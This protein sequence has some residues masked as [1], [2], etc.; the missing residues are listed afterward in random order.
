MEKKKQEM[1][2]D[3]ADGEETL[4]KLE[5]QRSEF[6]W[7]MREQEAKLEE[8]K[9]KAKEELEQQMKTQLND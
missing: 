1:L 2:S 8:D 3:G 6:E 5:K 7:K 9:R 4:K